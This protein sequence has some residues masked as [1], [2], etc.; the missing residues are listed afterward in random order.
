MKKGV[1]KILHCVIKC[2][3]PTKE[4]LHVKNTNLNHNELLHDLHFFFLSNSTIFC[5]LP[6]YSSRNKFMRFGIFW[7][8]DINLLKKEKKWVL[9]ATFFQK[10]KCIVNQSCRCNT[11][12]LSIVPF[13]KNQ[14]TLNHVHSNKTRLKFDV[15]NM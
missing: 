1:P 2:I 4:K 15:K 7:R 3:T 14:C 5:R 8:I 12:T 11:W 10:S 6:T 13:N 9:F